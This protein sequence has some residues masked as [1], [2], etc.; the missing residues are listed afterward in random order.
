MDF[1]FITL[2]KKLGELF[3]AEYVTLLERVRILFGSVFDIQFVIV[4]ML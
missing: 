1:L 3:I 2:L 4:K